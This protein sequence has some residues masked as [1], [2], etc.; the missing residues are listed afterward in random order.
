MSIIA[1]RTF[2]TSLQEKLSDTL[3][4][5]MM[6]TTIDAVTELLSGYD[7]EQIPS[8]A[9]GEK[10]FMLDAY[11]SAMRS[12]GLSEKT[13]DRYRYILTRALKMFQVPTRSVTNYHIRKYFSDEMER[14][15]KD[16]T[17]KGYYWCFSA[18][19]GWLHRDGLIQRNPM[20]NI[21][22]IKCQKVVKKVFSEVDIEKL[23]Q[24]CDNSR[25]LAI[26][27]F[28]KSTG[29]RISEV[30]RLNRTDIDFVHNELI[31]LGKGNKQRTVY[32]DPVTSM[33][34]KE[35]LD[36]RTDTSEALFYGK[37]STG[38]RLHP[39]GVRAMLNRLGEKSG[40]EHVHPHKFRRTQITELVN[41]GM[42]IEQVKALAGHEKLDTTMGY[43]VLD[44]NN[45][46]NS[47]MKFS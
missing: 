5:A 4:L 35:D 19:F 14:G 31:V 39:G 28:L 40:V 42:P 13:L 41:R 16:S 15:I 24:A 3:P 38:H 43:V 11:L 22:K 2:V 37:R 8:S 34:L 46:K 17:V 6:K 44:N 32:I 1:N 47:Y 18:Y 9:A 29:C 12:E 20:S 23:K 36:S 33:L 30:T 27:C 25:D 21:G 7:I 26:V 10:D 45:I